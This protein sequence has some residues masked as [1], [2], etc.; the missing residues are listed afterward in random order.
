MAISNMRLAI[1]QTF[2]NLESYVSIAS[3][4]LPELDILYLDKSLM[5]VQI[6]MPLPVPY[7]AVIAADC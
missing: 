5:K 3:R 4:Q 7:Y 1:V 6:L 2:P